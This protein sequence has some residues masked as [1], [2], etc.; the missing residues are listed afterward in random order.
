LSPLDSTSEHRRTKF[1]F[2]KQRNYRKREDCVVF[3]KYM[4]LNLAISLMLWI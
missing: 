2:G 1:E 3:P 4:S